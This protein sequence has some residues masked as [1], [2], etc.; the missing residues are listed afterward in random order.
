MGN[1]E[2]TTAIIQA[3][4]YMILDL[5]GIVGILIEFV[6]TKDKVKYNGSV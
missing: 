5:G 1:M 6:D 3:D 4:H 2:C